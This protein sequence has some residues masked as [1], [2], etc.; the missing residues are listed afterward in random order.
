MNGLRLSGSL[1]QP[2][3]NVVL[4]AAGDGLSL[5]ASAEPR[6]QSR[7]ATSTTASARTSVRGRPYLGL[8][9]TSAPSCTPCSDLRAAPGS[10]RVVR[11]QPPAR[12][13]ASS[14][15]AVAATRS[16]P[17][18]DRARTQIQPRMQPRGQWNEVLYSAA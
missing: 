12:D 2:R 7:P 5:P 10:E 9:L 3:C 18:V 8:A 17:R 11:R 16:T 1:V 15:L 14:D 13:R 4:P 6:P